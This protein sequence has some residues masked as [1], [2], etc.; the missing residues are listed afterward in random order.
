MNRQSWNKMKQKLFCGGITDSKQA[1]LHDEFKVDEQGEKMI[2]KQKKISKCKCGKEFIC[3]M[4]PV[5]FLNGETILV[6]KMMLGQGAFAVIS[7]Q[8][9]IWTFGMV[10]L[11][12]L[13]L[14]P[15]F[16]NFF[17][18]NKIEINR[19]VDNDNKEETR[20]TFLRRMAEKF[21][22]ENNYNCLVDNLHN[23]LSK[24]YPKVMSILKECFN[25]NQIIRADSSHLLDLTNSKINNF[26]P[27]WVR[28]NKKERKKYLSKK[29]KSSSSTID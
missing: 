14:A 19:I 16:E 4:I 1:L 18:E 21:F 24:H 6:S 29:G 7:K 27:L 12:L 25:E 5:S 23:I 11:D 20:I 3:E 17:D 13:T 26:E 9:D 15:L 8:T 10:C 2:R 22:I 28:A